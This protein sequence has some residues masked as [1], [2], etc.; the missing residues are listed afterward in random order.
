MPGEERRENLQS[1]AFIQS[2][3]AVQIPALLSATKETFGMDRT[4]IEKLNKI[5][6]QD[7]P[8]LMILEQISHYFT[9][10]HFQKMDMRLCP[11]RSG[12]LG[13]NET[14]DIYR[15]SWQSQ[16]NGCIKWKP[17]GSV[18]YFNCLHYHTGGCLRA[19][20]SSAPLLL[21]A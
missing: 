17:Q 15:N 9:A 2:S 11:F 13:M 3:L 1:A 18:T 21:L 12:Y 8:T 7:V 10:T 19:S 5:P 16:S 6:K 4:A 14:S 20:S